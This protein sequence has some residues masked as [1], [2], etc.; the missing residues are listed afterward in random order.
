LD[1]AARKVFDSNFD[2]VLFLKGPNAKLSG[3]GSE[4]DMVEGWASK[5]VDIFI[6]S[7]L[8]FISI[9][10]YLARKVNLGRVVEMINK[11]STSSRASDNFINH[12]KIC[13]KNL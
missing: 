3:D 13:V 2:R 12:A 6:S 7:V 5:G 4:L 9:Q 11:Y 10:I 1:H 8:D